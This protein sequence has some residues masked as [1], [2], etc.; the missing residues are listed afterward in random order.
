MS[1]SSGYCQTTAFQRCSNALANYLERQHTCY[2]DT[3]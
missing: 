1:T 2:Y 3:S